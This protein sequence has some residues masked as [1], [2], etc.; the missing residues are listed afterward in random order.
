MFR[1]E[2]KLKYIWNKGKLPEKR[3]TEFKCRVR[4][5]KQK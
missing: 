5:V 4:P 3:K 2:T 1:H